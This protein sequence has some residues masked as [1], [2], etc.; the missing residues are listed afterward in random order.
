MEKR[1]TVSS[2]L[3]FGTQVWLSQ[4]AFAHSRVGLIFYAIFVGIPILALT[5]ISAQQR[6]GYRTRRIESA[7]SSCRRYR[8]CFFHW[9]R[10]GTSGRP[11]ARTHGSADC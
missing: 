3:S 7:S 1:V 8:F 9:P 4:V 2:K 11:G 10:L 6:N 5:S